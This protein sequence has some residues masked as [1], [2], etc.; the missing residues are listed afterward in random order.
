MPKAILIDP[1]KDPR[2][3]SFVAAHPHGRVCH[4]AGWKKVL[5]S[6]FGHLK[7]YYYVVEDEKGN[8]RAGLPVFE[9]KSW[10]L[11]N[12]LVSMPFSTLCDPLLSDP[13][14][15]NLLF[16]AV[17]KLAESKAVSHV[18][19][20][21]LCCNSFAP[22]SGF[23]QV[24]YH[25]YHYLDLN[26]SINNIQKSFHRS[27]RYN[28]RRS[29]KEELQVADIRGKKDIDVFYRLYCLTRKHIGLPPQPYGF[30][31]N[32][33]DYLAATDSGSVLFALHQGRIVAGGIFLKNKDRF[34][35][36]YRVWD[37]KFNALRPNYFLYWE[38]IKKAHA[39]GYALFDFG[40][41]SISNQSLLEFKGHWGTEVADMP[42][43][44]LSEKEDSAAVSQEEKRSYQ[45]IQAFSRKCPQ[46]V[47]KWL[48][49][50]FYRHLG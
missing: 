31:K 43:F 28:I 5:E 36:E 25:K 22:A 35:D 32:Y 24:R 45:L 6:S 9:V 44:I 14:D 8:I 27:T 33:I 4:T 10:L 7:G 3:D 1:E 18:E 12:R 20:K 21:T 30:I 46:P 42:H 40:R 26:R 13:K 39:D 38:A 41:T 49:N 34:S 19:I 29:E 16:A 2:W 17:V 50:F 23:K 48:G 11:G 15:M 37:R 47:F